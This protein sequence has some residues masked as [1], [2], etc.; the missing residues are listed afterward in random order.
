MDMNAAYAPSDP[1]D[2][3]HDMD[4]QMDFENDQDFDM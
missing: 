4:E 2:F 3:D 1:I